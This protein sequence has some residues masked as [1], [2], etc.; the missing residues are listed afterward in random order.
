MLVYFI[1]YEYQNES[2]INIKIIISSLSEIISFCLEIIIHTFKY[3]ILK[4][5]FL[6]FI[7]TI[8]NLR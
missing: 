4:Y 6:T 8:K 2:K 3:E 7:N 5:Y 1:Y